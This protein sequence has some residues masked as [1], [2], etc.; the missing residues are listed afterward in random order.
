MARKKKARSHDAIISGVIE[1]N[2][3]KAMADD[4]PPGI[5]TDMGLCVVAK[6]EGGGEC[7]IAGFGP[8]G[9]GQMWCGNEDGRWDD[10]PGFDTAPVVRRRKKGE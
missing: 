4:G 2:V 6:T 3:A 10:Y 8:F 9:V 5:R 7:L 1:G